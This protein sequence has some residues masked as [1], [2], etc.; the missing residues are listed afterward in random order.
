MYSPP[1]ADITTEA[2][3]HAWAMVEEGFEVEYIFRRDSYVLVVA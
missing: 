1:R 3:Y 2:I